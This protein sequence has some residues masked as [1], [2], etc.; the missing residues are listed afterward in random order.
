[1][2]T[3]ATIKH[4]IILDMGTVFWFPYIRIAYKA[5][6]RRDILFSCFT[7]KQTGDPLATVL[8]ARKADLIEFK[9]SGSVENTVTEYI[10]DP[11]EIFDDVRNSYI[12]ARSMISRSRGEFLEE[13]SLNIDWSRYRAI[14]LPTR[15]IIDRDR[16]IFRYFAGNFEASEYAVAE[17]IKFLIEQG[18][19]IDDSIIE[20]G[21]EIVETK[22]VWYPIVVG[23]EGNIYEPAWKLER[24]IIFEW[25]ESNN[26][27]FRSLIGDLRRRVG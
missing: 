10:A 6:K 1:M 23:G 8:L 7:S 11:R 13:M 27:F 2:Y 22:R 5:D 16:P 3:I 17:F 14:F 18:L 12:S 19:G 4:D 20:K 15:R 21:I 24:S 25:L 9:S 26:D